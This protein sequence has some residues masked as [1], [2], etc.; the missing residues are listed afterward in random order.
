[1][2]SP[3]LLIILDGWG[4]SK[5]L[6]N[7]AIAMANTPVYDKLVAD[8]PMALLEASGESV[9]LPSGQMGNSEVGH[10]HIGAGR[11]VPQSLLKIN[12]TIASDK[13]ADNHV[14][15]AMLGDC[16]KTLHLIG[17]LSPGGV[18]SHE[19]HLFALLSLAAQQGVQRIAVHAILDGRDT[20]PQ[21]ALASLQA[22]QQ[23][24]DELT[25]N[26]GV[27]S[28]QIATICG[29]YY[30][31][32]RDSRWD[33]TAVA[34]DL[35][36]QP[37]WP[38]I[39]E[40]AFA[41]LEQAYANGLT[42]EFVQPTR[43]ADTMIVE[44]DSVIM[45]NFRA[46]R[47]RQLTKALSLPNFDAFARQHH[48]RC[49]ITTMTSYQDDLPVQVIFPHPHLTDTLGECLAKHGLKQCRIAETEKFAHVTYFLNGGSESVFDGEDRILIPS[50]KSVA[51]YDQAPAMKAKPI[52]EA[53]IKAIQ[54]RNHHVIICNFAN[55]DMVGH[56][57]NLEATIQAIETIDASLG[58]VLTCLEQ[59]QG[60]AL[61]TADHGNAEAMY[62]PDKAQAHTAHTTNPV[63]L[64]YVGPKAL[65]TTTGALSD[66]APTLLQGVG[67]TQ[68]DAMTGQS[69]I[70][71][72][73]LP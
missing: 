2:I 39:A 51:T 68:P 54:A 22:C 43:T 24:L 5:I 53:I 71:P 17:L 58:I 11:Q 73:S 7:N 69:L 3:T 33:R 38:Q 42:D 47:M 9:G 30:A 25:A 65:C 56:T 19:E 23:H 46:D 67:I 21:S 64:I 59:H 44:G 14:I 27:Q 63:P 6:E 15:K 8:C 40:H 62:N 12:Q 29:R 45:V 37:S 72:K 50:D 36:T 35:Y 34:Y 10:I 28:A 4:Y 48:P 13:L 26:H 60:Q 41:G 18:H 49:H 61:I 1:M 52:T 57:G 16:Q 32:D 55:A 66:I 31:M 70:Q 20:A